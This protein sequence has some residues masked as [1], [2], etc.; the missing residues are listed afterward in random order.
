LKKTKSNKIK[1]KIIDFFFYS[2]KENFNAKKIG[3]NFFGNSFNEF[4][5]ECDKTLFTT[6]LKKIIQ[7]NN[8][9]LQDI[10]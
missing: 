8:N 10:Q 3:E 1:K 4:I 9:I 7:K 2:F 6:Y 5:D